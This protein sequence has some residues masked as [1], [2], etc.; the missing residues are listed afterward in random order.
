MWLVKRP[1]FGLALVAVLAIV[2]ARARAEDLPSP[3]RLGDVLAG[4]R[5]R[6]PALAE[7]RKL[8]AAGEFR[9]RAASQPDD[10]MVMLEWWQQPVDFSTVP[11]MLTLKQPLPWPSR[12][13]LRREIAERE[14]QGLGE[15]AAMIERRVEAEAKRA[16][17]ELALAE[18]NL[19]VNGMVRT[20][21]KNLVQITDA[22]Y[23]VG[24]AVQADLLR[25]QAELLG[26][27][28]D[29]FDLERDRQASTAQLNGLL[30][31]APGAPLGPT[32]TPPQVL[33]VPPE[34][35][36]VERAR[37]Q[38]PEV[39][40]A[41][42]MLAAAGSRVALAHRD[43]YPELSVWGSFMLN[44][45]GINT[46]TAGVSS[47]LPVF[48]ITR[49]RALA[50]AAELE[51][52]AAR[53]ALDG[54]RRQTDVEVHTALLQLAAAQR[55]VQLHAEKLI[56]LADLTLQSAG[57]SY[58]AGRVPF[59]TVIEAARMVRDHHLNHIKFL[60]EYERRLAELEQVVGES[61]RGDVP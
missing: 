16:Y 57:S 18:R 44:I 1:G 55:H 11:L 47:T 33:A 45:R 35:E 13:R 25:A 37:K 17:F 53:R 56:P 52:E 22:Q 6:N 54:I 8:A 59:V 26:I 30:D 61:V 5:A 50:S 51:V 46:F 36:L 28:N 24:K 9:P 40:R 7:R 39:R 38:R 15:E 41:Q 4:V 23:R 29:G 12:L 34:A 32:A 48:S 27:E 43:N 3:L 31:R 49:K 19:A 14:A 42:T 21:I 58:Q 2:S 60:V 10:P 20:L